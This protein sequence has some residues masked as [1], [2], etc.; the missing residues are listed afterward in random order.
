MVGWFPWVVP[1]VGLYL[2]HGCGRFYPWLPMPGLWAG[3]SV[4]L[5]FGA[6]A[7]VVCGFDWLVGW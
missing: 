3:V 6:F 7:M 2:C 5:L 4:Y 1:L